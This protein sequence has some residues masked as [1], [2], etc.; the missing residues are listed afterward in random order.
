[1]ILEADAP[2]TPPEEGGFSLLSYNI[3]LPNPDGA[4]PAGPIAGS[5]SGAPPAGS[6][7]G[8]PAASP[9]D[10]SGEGGEGRGW[11]VFK[12][13]EAAVPEEA[14]TWP[15]RLELL[16]AS[17]L[18]ARADIVCLQEM[19]LDSFGSDWAFLEGYASVLHR[20]GDI[21]CATFWRS[22]RFTLAAEPQHKDRTL[23]TSLA[24]VTSP[25]RLVHVINCHLKA[26]A[27]PGRR[28]RQVTDAL[29]QAHKVSRQLGE[30]APRLVMAGDF[31]SN[32][33]GTAV[34]QLLREGEVSPSF[35][36]ARYGD[37]E[38]SS[39]VKKQPFGPFEDAYEQA[40][41][42]GAAPLTL[43]LPDRQGLLLDEQGELRPALE[44]AFRALFRRFSGTSDRMDR[45][46]VDR[47]ITTIN[48]RPGR[49]SEWTKARV[50]FQERG[51]EQLTEDDLVGIYRAELREGKPWGV[52]HD[53]HACGA[54]PEMRPPGV[55]GGR[56]DQI[57]YTARTLS[58]AAVREPLGEEL[59]ERVWGQRETLPNA[60]HPSD[61]LPV[62]ATLRW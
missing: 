16:R 18:A 51:T 49:G 40:Y 7:A 31:N 55:F 37:L 1:M 52:L 3:L 60:W 59:R 4:P 34:E 48:R 39:K 47:W 28:L 5:P 13:Y 22:D 33:E 61:H 44:E 27:D 23:L 32:P 24:S 2:L 36:E 30:E 26:G 25:G 12:Y 19:D 11:W 38:L 8:L 9:G 50:L 6:Q 62:G 14:R 41:G 43:L 29:E 45:A 17:L 15:R 20:K 42:R 35:R 10:E 54:M 46:A 21:R 56:F 53:L 57:H 58:L